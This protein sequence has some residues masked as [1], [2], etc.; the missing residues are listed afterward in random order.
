MG[1]PERNPSA[2]DFSGLDIVSGTAQLPDGRAATSKFSEW[3]SARLKERASLWKQERLFNQERRQL[4]GRG[5]RGDG[6]D[7]DSSEEDGK[8]N[9]K[10][11]KKKKK[12]GKG[13][14]STSGAPAGGAGG[15][16]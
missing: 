8:G 3:V 11:K 7:D 16:K 2:P 10:K 14:A 9:R 12:G 1:D 15:G 13:E 6:E 5:Y 4:R